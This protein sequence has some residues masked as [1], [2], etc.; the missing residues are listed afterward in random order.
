MTLPG[1]SG[2]TGESVI[3]TLKQW[4]KGDEESVSSL[5]GVLSSILIYSAGVCS[6]SVVRRHPE[7]EEVA[8][9]VSGGQSDGEDR[10]CSELSLGARWADCHED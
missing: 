9:G 10:H 5:I 2:G 3:H 1:L 7:E 8:G 6:Q 4:Y